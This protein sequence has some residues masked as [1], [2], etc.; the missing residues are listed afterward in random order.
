VLLIQRSII[1]RTSSVV[2]SLIRPPPPIQMVDGQILPGDLLIWQRMVRI[3]LA[4]PPLP[5]VN[6]PDAVA[7]RSL[8]EGMF[9]RI[10]EFANSIRGF[11]LLAA[12]LRGNTAVL[13][14]AILLETPRKEFGSFVALAVGGPLSRNALGRQTISACIPA[15]RPRGLSNFSP[16][17]PLERGLR[18]VPQ[19]FRH[20]PKANARPA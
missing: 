8:M 10:S 11:S 3:L 16:E 4:N 18:F 19:S 17:R 12:C 20:L 1:S 9:T 5:Y 14:L 15:I 2:Y 7:D 6:V 13:N